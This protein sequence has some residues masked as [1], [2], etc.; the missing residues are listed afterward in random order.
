MLYPPKP[1][2][3]RRSAP[4][5]TLSQKLLQDFCL[6]LFGGYV[7][8][9]SP[10]CFLAFIDG[11]SAG[12]LWYKLFEGSVYV[13]SLYVVPSFRG[14]GLGRK[15]LFHAAREEACSE[16]YLLAPDAVLPFYKKLGFVWERHV[17]QKD[18]KKRFSVLSK[19]FE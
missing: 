11:V 12:G 19:K 17:V 2:I 5:S 10:E 4:D 15:L 6:E 18:V 1:F 14:E 8:R 13:E 9:D 16:M 7:E 3:Q